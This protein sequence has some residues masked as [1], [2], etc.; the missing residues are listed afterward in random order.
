MFTNYYKIYSKCFVTIPFKVLYLLQ[1]RFE[2]IN[3]IIDSCVVWHEF[4]KFGKYIKICFFFCKEQ[5]EQ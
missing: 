5:S 3:L 1:S 2:I 4:F